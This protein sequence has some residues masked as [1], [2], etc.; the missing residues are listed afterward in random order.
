MTERDAL[1]ALGDDELVPLMQ[2]PLREVKRIWQQ[3]LEE[4]LPA[5]VSACPSCNTGP[6]LSLMVR[7]EDAAQVLALL[8]RDWK[9]LVD[10]EGVEQV[11]GAIGVEAAEGEEP[12]CPACGTAA[13]LDNGACTECGLQLE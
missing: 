4:D 8:Q 13:P 2:G 7:K 12:P 5:A 1:E 10:R 6:R 3:C 9:D 11:G